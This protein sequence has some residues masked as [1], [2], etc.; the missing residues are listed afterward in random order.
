M[1]VLG[2]ELCRR[3]LRSYPQTGKARV[4]P[5]AEGFLGPPR[6]GEPGIKNARFLPVDLVLEA[7]EGGSQA[8]RVR[9]APPR[10]QELSDRRLAGVAARDGGRVIRRLDDE[11][12]VG[13]DPILVR[14]LVDLGL[15]RQPGLPALERVDRNEVAVDLLGAVGVGED[16]P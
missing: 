5:P 8:E 16:L 11:R 3:R 7:L 9:A 13:P 2:L 4:D 14:E 12:R 10:R 6:I 15:G 1:T